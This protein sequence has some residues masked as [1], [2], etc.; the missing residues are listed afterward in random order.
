MPPNIQHRPDVFCEKVAAQLLLQDNLK[1]SRLLLMSDLRNI[2]RNA[3]GQEGTVA[4]TD[5]NVVNDLHLQ[6]TTPA[7]FL[8]LHGCRPDLSVCAQENW[9]QLLRPRSSQLKFKLPYHGPATFSYLKVC[10]QKMHLLVLHIVNYILYI[11]WSSQGD[12][13]MQKCLTC[14]TYLAV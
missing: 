8:D 13:M 1:S 10:H 11:A 7:P 2:T 5:D 4:V 6:A 12:V 14:V 3:W 9:V